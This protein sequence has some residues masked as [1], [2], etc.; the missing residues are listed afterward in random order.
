MP[1]SLIDRFQST[2]LHGIMSCKTII[3]LKEKFHGKFMTLKVGQY[4]PCYGDLYDVLAVLSFSKDVMAYR[5]I[6]RQ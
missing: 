3:H 1:C 6:A 2:S 4:L 5:P